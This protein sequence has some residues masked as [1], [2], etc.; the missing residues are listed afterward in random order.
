MF[1]GHHRS[2]KQNASFPHCT[3]HVAVSPAH[4]VGVRERG[5]GGERE[6]SGGREGGEWEERGSE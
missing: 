3:E 6:G 5:V 1:K 4:M 2:A